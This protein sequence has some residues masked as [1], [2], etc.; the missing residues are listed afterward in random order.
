MR[1]TVATVAAGLLA[2]CVHHPSTCAQGSPAGT[3]TLRSINAAPMPVSL[4]EGGGYRA[5]MV[6]VI[7]EVGAD[8]RFT[9]RSHKRESLNGLVSDETSPDVGTYVVAGDSLTLRFQSDGKTT[10][11]L[12]RC[13]TL[14]MQERG[15]TYLF[16][17]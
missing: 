14:T 3:W 12:V 13:E 6:A 9:I 8:G 17:R 11:A 7:L 5:E 2:A 1:A 15:G 16:T 10:S 4:G